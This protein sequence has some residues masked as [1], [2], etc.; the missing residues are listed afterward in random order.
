MCPDTHH[1][2]K[3]GRDVKLQTLSVDVDLL[4]LAVTLG[5]D[6]LVLGELLPSRQLSVELTQHHLGAVILVLNII[7]VS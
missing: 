7:N 5:D 6:D 1:F 2:A 4:V 3:E